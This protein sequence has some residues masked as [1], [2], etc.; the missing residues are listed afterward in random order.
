MFDFVNYSFYK[1]IIIISLSIKTPSMASH[2]SFFIFKTGNFGEM[3]KA[4][5]FLMPLLYHIIPQIAIE[6][7]H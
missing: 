5:C 3:P 6:L 7:L 4:E 1:S 2:L